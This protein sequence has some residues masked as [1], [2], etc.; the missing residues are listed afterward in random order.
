MGNWQD[1]DEPVGR[2]APRLSRAAVKRS[3][4]VPRA[5]LKVATRREPVETGAT[6]SSSF[7]SPSPGRGAREAAESPLKGLKG[8]GRWAFGSPF[9]GP[10][11]ARSA[12]RSDS[13]T[14]AIIKRPNFGA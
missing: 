12:L 1:K 7:V 4:R 6:D 5:R 13:R 14:V 9:H 10:A 11:Q 2:G 3:T 8:K